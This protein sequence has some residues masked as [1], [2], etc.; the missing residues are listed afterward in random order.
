MQCPLAPAATPPSHP[1]PTPFK[2]VISPKNKHPRLGRAISP[3]AS[4]IQ[5]FQP[6]HDKIQTAEGEHNTSIADVLVFTA[7]PAELIMNEHVIGGDGVL[8]E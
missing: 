5:Q 3:I 1:Q 4:S 8:T 2:S 7:E 6:L